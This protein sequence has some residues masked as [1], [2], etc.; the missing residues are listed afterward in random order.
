MPFATVRDIDIYYEIHGQG[1][2]LLFISGSGGDLRNKPNMFDGP[3]VKHFE[4]LGYDQRGLGQTSHPDIPY[5]MQDYAADAAGLLE[6]VGWDRCLVLGVSFG[7][8]VAQEFAIRYPHTI[9]RLVLACTSSGG[10]GGA[11]Y[12]LHEL[13]DLPD[14]EYAETIIELSDLRCDAA[15]RVE[16]P[17]KYGIV[18]NQTLT[19]RHSRAGDEAREIGARRQ[20]EA[21]IG[22]DTY[23]R[24]PALPMPVK[25]VGGR[26]D[27]IAP[28]ENLEALQRQIPEAELELFKGGHMF[29]IQDRQAFQRIIE[30]FQRDD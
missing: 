17:D 26:Y 27:G 3:L 24:L 20:L 30:F 13:S 15:W 23:Q 11:S 6:A 12:P 22:H 5:T 19:G 1:P 18:K 8:M 4:V 2:R 7:G 21:R 9:E 25:I 16:N 28:V 29:L 14:K 10:T